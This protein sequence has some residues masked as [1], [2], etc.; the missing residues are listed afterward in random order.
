MVEI[1]TRNC[2]FVNC[3]F[4]NVQMNGA[5]HEGSSFTNC[6]FLAGNLFSTVFR[7]CKMTGSSF[8]AA[9][10]TGFSVMGGDWSYVSL[11]NHAL[12]AQN[13][14][15]VLLVEADLYGCDLQKADL[16]RADLTRA[17]LAQ[18]QLKG[19]DLRGAKTEGLDWPAFSVQGVRM[20]LD[21]AMEFAKSHG[22][23]IG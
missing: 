18:A 6:I 22:A 8:E 11:R 15:G 13:L 7:D 3:D 16:R 9:N 14:Q 4:T 20:D 1:V 23:K 5:I 19:A 12:K 10:L 17:V 2:R 21:Q